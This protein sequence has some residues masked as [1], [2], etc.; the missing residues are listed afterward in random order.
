MPRPEI[1]FITGQYV[2]RCTH[3]I[4]KYFADYQTLQ[5][6]EAGSVLVSIDGRAYA[7]NGRSFWSAYPGPRIA[8]H[9]HPPTRT[10][11]HRYLAFRGPLVQRWME[12][13]LFPVPP[14]PA[15][16]NRSFATRFDEAMRRALSPGRWSGVRAA[17]AVE[18]MLIDLAE[19]RHAAPTAPA[20]VTEATRQLS[21]A[22]EPVDYDALSQ[23]LGLS[24][25]SLRRNFR[26]RLG[27]TPHQYVIA[28]RVSSARE[29]L[30]KTDTPLKEIARQ[31][32]YADVFYFARQFKRQ[33]GVSP[34]RFRRSRE[35]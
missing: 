32:G 13:G 7:L 9:A 22:S 28:Q 5:Y 26:K 29:L 16:G 18:G 2:P 23:R 20:W 30:L 12:D 31:L 25:R 11:V 35:G 21:G 34:A 14:Q 6:M 8:F 4:D 1:T 10:W 15:P 3:D 33:T 19:A 27:T 17:H 24:V